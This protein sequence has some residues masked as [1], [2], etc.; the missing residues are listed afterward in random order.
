MDDGTAATAGWLPL[1]LTNEFQRDIACL[2]W[3]PL[4][5]STIAAGVQSGVCLW[6]VKEGLIP[7]PGEAWCEFLPFPED[8]PV[9]SLAWSPLG[10]VHEWWLAR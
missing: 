7:Y 6:R 9:T 3:Q 8:K 10:Q 2:E 1:K 4:S 5:G